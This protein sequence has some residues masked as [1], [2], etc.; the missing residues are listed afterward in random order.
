MSLALPSIAKDI[1]VLSGKFVVQTTETK[2]KSLLYTVEEGGKYELAPDLAAFATEG[3]VAQ[4]RSSC[5]LRSPAEK[6]NFFQETRGNGE[7]RQASALARC[8]VRSCKPR[9][10]DLTPSLSLFTAIILS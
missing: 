2:A 9:R 7:A 8:C 6:Y 1:G 3:S 5:L 4:A 10:S